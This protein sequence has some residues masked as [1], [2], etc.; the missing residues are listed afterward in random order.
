MKDSS[1]RRSFYSIMQKFG[2]KYS[3][4]Y[5]NKLSEL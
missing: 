2:K 1:F 3:N 5:I 4:I